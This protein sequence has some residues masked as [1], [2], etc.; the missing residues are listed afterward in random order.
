MQQEEQSQSDDRPTISRRCLL[1]MRW[2]GFN[3]TVFAERWDVATAG[4]L[5]EFLTDNDE[6]CQ[7]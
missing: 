2:V 6:H 4:N 3:L 5:G 7:V 1:I